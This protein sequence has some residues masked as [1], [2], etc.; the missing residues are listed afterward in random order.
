MITGNK[1][2]ISWYSDDDTWRLPDALVDLTTMAEITGLN[3]MELD[4]YLTASGD[5]AV[6]E[7]KGEALWLWNTLLEL[8]TEKECARKARADK[9]Q[10]KANGCTKH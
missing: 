6:A 4:A 7:Y 3:E 10:G 8:L 2:K 9:R 1:P 5:I